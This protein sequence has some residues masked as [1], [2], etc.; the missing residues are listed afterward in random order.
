MKLCQLDTGSTFILYLVS[1]NSTYK[2]W[3]AYHIF[4]CMDLT[5]VCFPECLSGG[6]TAY[7]FFKYISQFWW[8]HHQFCLGLINEIGNGIRGIVSF[9]ST[10][11]I[12]DIGNQDTFPRMEVCNM[13]FYAP[14]SGRKHPTV[15]TCPSRFVYHF[16]SILYF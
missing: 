16:S 12:I 5:H 11:N 10:D 8:R 15:R 4:L 1:N 2:V 9:S 14:F 13:S 7:L 6:L 3:G